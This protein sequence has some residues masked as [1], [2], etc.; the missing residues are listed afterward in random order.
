M[1][2]VKRWLSLSSDYR[3][4][5]IKLCPGMIPLNCRRL[6]LSASPLRNSLLICEHVDEWRRHISFRYIWFII[7]T[8]VPCSKYQSEWALIAKYLYTW[9]IYCY[10]RLKKRDEFVSRMSSVMFS[11][12]FLSLD[13]CKDWAWG[14]EEKTSHAKLL[15]VRNVDWHVK[16]ISL[17]ANINFAREETKTTSSAPQLPRANNKPRLGRHRKALCCS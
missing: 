7:T 15:Y 12:R 10:Y 6:T 17:K 2:C 13:M 8:C 9:A 14:R 1:W 4:E 16:L 11:A 5:T 3:N